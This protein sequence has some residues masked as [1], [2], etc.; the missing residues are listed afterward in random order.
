M[1][2]KKGGKVI[3]IGLVVVGVVFGAKYLQNRPKSVTQAQSL[4]KIALPDAPEA[5][6]GTSATKLALPGSEQ[7]LNGG[8]RIDFYEMAWAAQTSLNFANGGDR[9]T[10]GSLID[11]AGVDAKIIR[12]SSTRS[13]R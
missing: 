12:S 3:L 2:I 4:G 11:H 1:A 5:S 9:T 7:A 6:L 8:L 13:K 10:K